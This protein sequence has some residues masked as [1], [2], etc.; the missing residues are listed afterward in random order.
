MPAKKTLLDCIKLADSRGGKCLSEKYENHQTNLLWQCAQDHQWNAT[1]NNV[2]N[3]NSWCPHCNINFGEQLSKIILETLLECEFQ[4]CR[5]DFLEGLELDGYSEYLE[6]AFEYNG[7]QHYKKDKHFHRESNAFASQLE[8]DQ[9]KIKL[10]T[11]KVAL[12]I[13]P[14]WEY[15][16]GPECLFRFIIKELYKLGYGDLIVVDIE[17]NELIPMI[18]KNAYKL[19]PGNEE[20]MKTLKDAVESKGYK[21]LSNIYGGMSKIKYLIECDKNHKY[22]STGDNIVDI[23]G[24]FCPHPECNGKPTINDD[25]IG[26]FALKRYYQFVD[27]YNGKNSGDL[28]KFKCILNHEILM[29]WDNFKQYKNC[30]Y[31]FGRD[32]KIQHE[33]FF[34]IAK[35]HN[36]KYIGYYKNLDTNLVFFDQ[37]KNEYM[38]EI[39]RKILQGVWVD[40]D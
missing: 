17:D 31:C 8:R 27:N 34:E 5:P 12:I 39:A 18:I 40:Q 25:I 23:R 20:R 14:Y 29:S 24:R 35:R 3:K 22:E 1:Y 37:E 16:N 21:L 32:S 6:L 4:K 15:D 2:A 19:V 7:I 30:K 13:I 28:L 26:K 36:F 38:Q 33:V 10:C 9:K 11:G